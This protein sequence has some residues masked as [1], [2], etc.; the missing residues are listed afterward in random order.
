M[1]K[2]HVH[3]TYQKMK[4]RNWD[5]LYWAIDIHDTCIKANYSTTEIPTEFFPFAKETLQYLSKKEYHCLIL[6][7]CSHQ[8]DVDKYLQLFRDN[9]IHFSYVNENPTVPN[10]ALGAYDKKFYTNFYIEDKA[11]FDANN[12]WQGILEALIEIDILKQREKYE[13]K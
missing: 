12:D 13:N 7:T 9:N 5:T 8:K 2:K 10:T 11:G 3:R 6:F 4:A 1:H